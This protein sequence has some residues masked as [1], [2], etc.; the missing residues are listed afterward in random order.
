MFKFVNEKF[1]LE[2]GSFKVS[3]SKD[4]KLPDDKKLFIEEQL[5]KTTIPDD[6][7]LT[8]YFDG[9]TFIVLKKE[10]LQFR[11]HGGSV[12]DIDATIQVNDSDIVEILKYIITKNG[13]D[14]SDDDSD[15]GNSD[16]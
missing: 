6:F 1:I 14:D 10:S 7:K 2:N 11:C 15:A 5:I 3:V 12:L 8:Y 16:E 4:L 13:N 9:D